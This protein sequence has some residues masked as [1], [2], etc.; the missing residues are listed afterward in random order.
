MSA[1]EV[2]TREP[3]TEG[4]DTRITRALLMVAA[5][6]QAGIRRDRSTAGRDSAVRMPAAR[7]KRARR[8]R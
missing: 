4:D 8:C 2:I 6:E 7:L 5:Q 1:T 3:E